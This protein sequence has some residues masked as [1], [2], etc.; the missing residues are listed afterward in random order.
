M[1]VAT[2]GVVW[3]TESVV[4]TPWPAL[5]CL[6]ITVL[7]GGVRPVT[8]LVTQL[9][10]AVQVVVVAAQVLGGAGYRSR[11]WGCI[12]L[13]GSR[14]W[15]G[16]RL[17]GSRDWGGVRL[18]G[19]RDWGWFWCS[20]TSI[21]HTPETVITVISFRTVRILH[22]LGA[23]GTI[24]TGLPRLAVAGG[25]LHGAGDGVRPVADRTD[26]VLEGEVEGQGVLPFAQGVVHC[27]S[28][29]TSTLKEADLISGPALPEPTAVI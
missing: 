5:L 28:V 7:A 17:L 14:D 27:H 29:A 24:D 23:T 8:R 18:L 4:W 26:G 16:V 2:D 6:S 13:L 19:S 9:M 11:N 12:W 25:R 22:A 1:I 20:F 10:L 21:R 15:G 3:G